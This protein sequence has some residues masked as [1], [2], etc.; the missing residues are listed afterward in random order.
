MTHDLE[1]VV[2]VTLSSMAVSVFVI[3]AC[4][5]INTV[6]SIRRDKSQF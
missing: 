3:A 5:I 6:R 1:L 4:Y 2:S